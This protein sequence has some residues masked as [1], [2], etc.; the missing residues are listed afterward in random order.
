MDIN[1]F[2]EG[3]K[4]TL[5]ALMVQNHISEKELAALCGIPYK[6]VRNYMRTGSQMPNA[7]NALVLLAAAGEPHAQALLRRIE[8]GLV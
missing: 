5:S 3:F 7:Q 6:T 2:M 8:K 4:I 1:T